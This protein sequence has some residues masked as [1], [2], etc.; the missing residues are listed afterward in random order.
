MTPAPAFHAISTQRSRQ[1]KRINGLGLVI[2][3]LPR[4]HVVMIDQQCIV[5][6]STQRCA[7][8]EPLIDCAVFR[9]RVAVRI[10]RLSAVDRDVTISYG[11]GASTPDL[12][13]N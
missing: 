9:P 3:F 5:P 4:P 6:R 1:I 2:S 12:R 8:P 13:F 7:D 11:S 10:A